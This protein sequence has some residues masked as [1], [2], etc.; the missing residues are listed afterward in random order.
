MDEHPSREMT[1]REWVDTLPPNHA[2]RE[3]LEA[4]EAENERLW[5]VHDAARECF[6]FSPFESSPETGVLKKRRLELAF[7]A[8]QKK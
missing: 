6:V 5:E 8:I 1:L 7:A 4:L 2:A 3:E